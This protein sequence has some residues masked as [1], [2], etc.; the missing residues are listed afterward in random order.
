[1]LLDHCLE[2]GY[3]GDP[4]PSVPDVLARFTSGAKAGGSR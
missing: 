4:L 3:L 1:V 2:S